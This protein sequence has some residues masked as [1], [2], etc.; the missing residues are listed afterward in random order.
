MVRECLLVGKGLKCVGVAGVFPAVLNSCHPRESCTAGTCPG[1]Q[2]S[3]VPEQ[4]CSYWWVPS[5]I[6]GRC[7]WR[8]A[9]A[10]Q[11]CTKSGVVSLAFR[12]GEFDH[13]VVI[14]KYQVSN[15]HNGPSLLFVPRYGL[16]EVGVVLQHHS[17]R[18]TPKSGSGV[19]QCR[20]IS[21]RHRH[22]FI[23]YNS[24]D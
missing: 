7:Y 2:F 23:V 10:R 19:N 1:G 9:P 21:L 24:Q 16:K 4:G 3:T 14:D 22:S 17:C 18:P 11:G 13:G 5:A 20:M 12:M 6:V 8:F 15:L